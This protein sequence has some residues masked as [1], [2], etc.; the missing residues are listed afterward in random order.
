MLCWELFPLQ[1]KFKWKSIQSSWCFSS[2]PSWRFHRTERKQYLSWDASFYTPLGFCKLKWIFQRSERKERNDLSVFNVPKQERNENQSI[3]K[4]T[5]NVE[6]QW[7]AQKSHLISYRDWNRSVFRKIKR[8]LIRGAAL[9]KWRLFRAKRTFNYF[10]YRSRSACFKVAEHG[11]LERPSF[12]S[13]KK[14]L[15]LKKL[16]WW[17]FLAWRRFSLAWKN[18]GPVFPF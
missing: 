7:E 18:L 10:A 11:C 5:P 9:W 12:D 1:R 3:F 4:M 16:C 17:F 8:M 13:M 15:F 14:S 2:K 6:Y